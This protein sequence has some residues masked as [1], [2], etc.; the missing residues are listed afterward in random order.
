MHL[1]EIEM[2]GAQVFQGLVQLALRAG[3]VSFRCL[4][5]RENLAAER[6]QRRAE[7]LLR[8]PAGRGHVETVHPASNASCTTRS[9]C[10]CSSSITTIPPI[11]IIDSFSPVLPRAR[12]GRGADIDFLIITG[13]L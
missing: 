7:P 10:A 9:A 2:I 6:L 3:A 12:L 13:F 8:I 4:A 5:G 11:P 1:V